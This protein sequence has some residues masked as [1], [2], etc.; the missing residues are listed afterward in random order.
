MYFD[1][2]GRMPR[3]HGTIAFFH[4][5]M[6]PLC[7]ITGVWCSGALH[8]RSDRITELDISARRCSISAPGNRGCMGRKGKMM[9]NGWPQAKGRSHASSSR[10]VDAP[11]GYMQLAKFNSESRKRLLL[12]NGISAS[13]KTAHTNIEGRS[14]LQLTR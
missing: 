13:R 8:Q 12:R 10:A 7:A 4:W 9:Q 14:P 11:Q 1:K 5:K 6:V 2:C 3:H